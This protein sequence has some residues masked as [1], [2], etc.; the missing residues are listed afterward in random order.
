MTQPSSDTLTRTRIRV[1]GR[2]QGVG[3]RPFVFRVAQSLGL[4]GWVRND[5]LGVLI[6]VEGRESA[7]KTFKDKLVNEL[8]A[9]AAIDECIDEACAV[10]HEPA[11][12]IVASQAEGQ[13]L[14]TILPDLATC[15]DCQREVQDPS[16][17]RHRYPFTNC[18]HCGPRFT[19]IEALPYDRPNTTMAQFTMCADCQ[20]EYEDPMDRRFHAQPNACPVCGPQLRY[21]E[22]EPAL[23]TRY[24]TTGNLRAPA[25]QLA[26]VGAAPGLKARREH[27]LTVAVASILAGC[28]VAVQGL[29][30]FHLIVDATNETA[31]RRLRERKHRWEKPLAIMVGN[32]EQARMHVE[33]QPAVEQLL[34][35]SEAPIVLCRKCTHS[36]VAQSVAP[37]TPYLGVMIA[38]TPLH[39]LLLAAVQRPIVAT[40]G[41]LSEEPICIDPDEALSRLAGIADGWLVH[42]RPIERHMDDSVMHIV[43]H[44]PQ[45]LRRAR[46]FAPLPIA[47]PQS[48]LVVL[49]LGS[50]QK[51]TIALAVQDRVFVSQHIGDLD[52]LQTRQ[53]CER[54]VHDFLAL[55][56]VR[57]HVIAHDLHP[58]YAS[59]ELAEALTAPGA[60]LDAVPRIAVQHHHAHLAAGLADAGQQGQALGVIWDGSGLGMDATL[61][62]SEFLL[63]DAAGFERIAALKP[64]PLLGGEA[65]ARDP[66][67]SAL[68]LLACAL[69]P[70]AFEADD[71]PCVAGIPLRDRKL[72]H[73]M[74]LNRVGSPMTSSMGRLFD[75]VAALC[76]LVTHQSFEGRGGMLLETHC[77]AIEDAHYPLPRVEAGSA[78][79]KGA[80]PRCWL[81]PAPLIRAVVADVRA[82]T[83]QTTIATR[84]HAALVATVVDVASQTEVDCVVLSGGCFQNR[85]L[86]EACVTA[87]RD[88]KLKVIIH[89][90][91]PA[92]DGGLSLGQAMVARAL[93]APPCPPS[94]V[95][96]RAADG[97]GF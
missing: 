95:V 44:V 49:A 37:D 43:C 25:E 94:S 85:K 64:Y 74:F 42:D 31:V 26:L 54:V 30:G 16:D 41:N 27:A 45:F 2:V 58:D 1:R 13:K 84:F 50:H 22:S 72:L 55:Y 46:G 51:N 28:V 4:S 91:V 7:V 81:D 59:S 67:R 68:S 9:P 63:G 14:A 83:S 71:L 80:T 8:P 53:A 47:V 97:S 69:G 66:R 21:Y 23:G 73:K 70:D 92:N 36:T 34:T 38:S 61:W 89:R 77:D 12:V 87:L 17:R 52:S 32:L 29:G 93:T 82:G 75:A 62:G 40:S 15:R 11:F 96:H 19:I 60:L 39:H 86:T 65:A 33:L 18:T 24:T 3:F 90:G 76:N 5:A 88:L 48:D 57:P 35:S 56:A 6:E 20:R 79:A 10:Q 78:S